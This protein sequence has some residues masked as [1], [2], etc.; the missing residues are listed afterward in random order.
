MSSPSGVAFHDDARDP[1]E[2]LPHR[3]PDGRLR[4][5]WSPGPLPPRVEEGACGWEALQVLWEACAD[6]RPSHTLRQGCPRLSP[7]T[8]LPE[9]ALEPRCHL[10][11]LQQEG[12]VAGRRAQT[13]R[14]Y[15]RKAT[16]PSRA[17]REPVRQWTRAS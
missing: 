8:R 4:G 12:V 11:G 10:P 1:E 17:Y 16:R 7:P 9:P 15:A 5:V 3:D 2:P 14:R 13:L 6:R